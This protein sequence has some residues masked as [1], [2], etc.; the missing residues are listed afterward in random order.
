LLSLQPAFINSNHIA[1]YLPSKNEFD[2]QPI[3]DAIWQAEKICYL[4]VLSANS[5]SFVAYHPG[6]TLQANQ[7]NIPEPVDQ[8]APL[9]A[10][11]LDLVIL[12]LIAFDSMGHRLGTGG[13]YYD[14]TFA[15]L[16]N[17]PNCPV[18]LG[19]AYD[20]Q[21]AEGLPVDEW[22]VGLNAVI[23]ETGWRDFK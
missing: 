17:A 3:I 15:F 19:L 9:M 23:T 1:C 6:D 10:D 12:P 22:D 20:I 2:T 4:P 5:L 7:Y 13:G 21:Q 16:H 14:R 18:M 11:Q 8:S